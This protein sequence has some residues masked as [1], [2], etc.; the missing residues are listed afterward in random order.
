M[1]PIEQDIIKDL[2]DKD[3]LSSD[4]PLDFA[5]KP[6]DKPKRTLTLSDAEKKRRGDQLR[7]I[8]KKRTDESIQRKEIEMTQKEIEMKEKLQKLE[9]KKKQLAEAK[10]KRDEAKKLE[11]GKSKP[12]QDE[13]ILVN[14]K[15]SVGKEAHF[16]ASGKVPKK[17]KK[18]VKV[19]V[20]QSSSDSEDYSESDSSSSSEDEVIYVSKSKSKKP[21]EPKQPKEIP[22]TKPKSEPEVMPR[23]LPTQIF[24]FV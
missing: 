23:P 24:K 12:N 8:G 7:E 18:Q 2:V 3:I 15:V 21:K 5:L 22:I 6:R 9:E 11:S 16:L 19:I 4:V 17:P 10:A 1:N 13:E 14:G 20:E